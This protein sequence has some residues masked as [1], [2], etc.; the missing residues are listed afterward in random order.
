M[1]KSRKE[2][3]DS[4]DHVAQ[5][6]HRHE[7]L[8]SKIKKLEMAIFWEQ[9]RYKILQEVRYCI[10]VSLNMKGLRSLNRFKTIVGPAG[11]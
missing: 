11:R 6:A 8:K 1:M 3:Q 4:K 9:N 7:I 5:Y 2:D 10:H